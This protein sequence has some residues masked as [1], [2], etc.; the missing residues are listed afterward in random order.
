[1][2]KKFIPNGD[3]DFAAMAGHVMRTVAGDAEAY[4]VTRED[5]EELTAVVTRYAAA[6]QATKMG[7]RSSVATRAKEDARVAAEQVIRRIA[8]YIRGNPRVP[9]LTKYKLF[10]R[11]RAAK[12]KQLPCPQEPPRLR[13]VRALHE[14]GAAVP[15]HELKFESLEHGVAKPAGAV[16]LEL[17]VDLV[18]PEEPIP[19][20]PG[21]NL[22]GRPWYL[23][24]FTRSPIKLVP[25]MA[26]V[27]MRVV[28]WARWA[29]SVGN[30]GPFSATAVGWIE[31]ATHHY[32]PTPTH[33]RPQLMTTDP[34]ATGPATRDQRYIV[35]VLETIDRAFV[36]NDVKAS[37]LPAPTTREPRQLEGPTEDAQAA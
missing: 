23:R 26:R 24:S 35:A 6:L 21:A 4:H 12:A 13:F 8:G 22:A 27:A 34:T 15:V 32:M 29:D 16:R 33:N 7:E 17:F 36:A 31:G 37:A 9:P 20:H 2:S 3:Q 14:A 5:A 25:P 11:D 10:L 1:M 19:A 28:Y 18:P 30:V